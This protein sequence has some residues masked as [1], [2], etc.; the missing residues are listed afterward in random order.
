MIA[1]LPR[2]SSHSSAQALLARCTSLF[3][4][5]GQWEGA[6]IT[7]QRHTMSS[8]DESM[9]EQ[10]NAPSVV[11]APSMD[12][13]A[14][15]P[16]RDGPRTMIPLTWL[17]WKAL[18]EYT[19]PDGKGVSTSATLLDWCGLGIICAIAGARSIV[20]WNAIRIVELRGD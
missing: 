1:F 5:G 8:S 18:V 16:K 2:T 12:E 19:T 7:Q 3:H 17:G 14:P 13:H 20:A 9:V 6:V 11:T 10:I 15:L 4:S